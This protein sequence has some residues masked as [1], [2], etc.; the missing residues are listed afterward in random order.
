[1]KFNPDSLEHRRYKLMDLH[2]L[3][4][5]CVLHRDMPADE[6]ARRRAIAREVQY[7]ITMLTHWADLSEVQRAEY[8]AKNAN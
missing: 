5:S 4:Q 3:K 8:K 6:Q 1:M 7:H 2:T